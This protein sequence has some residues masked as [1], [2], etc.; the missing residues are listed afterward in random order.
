V[1]SEAGLLRSEPLRETRWA[2]LIRAQCLAGRPADALEAYA[3]ERAV[4]RDELGPDPGWELQQLQRATL[5]GDFASSVGAN[6][7][8]EI[9]EPLARTGPRLVG[10]DAEIDQLAARWAAAGAGGLLVVSG[11][12][13]QVG[14]GDDGPWRP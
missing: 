9:P 5:A 12:A 10:R 4:L 1:I 13:E 7:R 6:G 8:V 11:R 3:R 2:L 14:A